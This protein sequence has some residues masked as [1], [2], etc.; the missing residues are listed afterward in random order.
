M[1]EK[2]SNGT[3][4]PNKQ[5]N[6]QTNKE[7]H[8]QT[9]KQFCTIT[10]MCLFHLMYVLEKIGSKLNPNTFYFKLFLGS[11]GSQQWAS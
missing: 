7:T 8:K 10:D 3:K 1:S 2:F 9:N 5:T 11:F 4:T 6:K